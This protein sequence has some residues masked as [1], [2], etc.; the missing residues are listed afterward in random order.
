MPILR[1]IKGLIMNFTTLEDIRVI[2]RVQLPYQFDINKM[3]TEMQSI[4]QRGF[5]Y[6]DAIP[7]RAPA[8]EVDVSIPFPP[9]ASDY[10]DGSWTQWMNTNYLKECPYISSIID[11]FREH[12]TV[13][14]VRL[15]RLAPSA[16]VKEHTDPTLGLHIDKSMI[17]L[18]I[19]IL[20]ND[21]VEFY[22]NNKLVPMRAGECWYLNLTEPHRVINEG[23]EERINLTIDLIPNEWVT[24]M[25]T[26]AVSR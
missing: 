10:A 16:V 9:P 5:Q 13:N 1:K 4:R 8:H 2:E 12:T 23:T 11:L 15:L 19:P 18:T 22:L 26:S 25:I 14:L 7:L 20:V 3:V 21:K 17:R 24:N 6:Y